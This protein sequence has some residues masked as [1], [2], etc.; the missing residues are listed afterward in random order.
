MKLNKEYLEKWLDG[1]KKAWETKDLNE[2]S[3]IFSKIENYWENEDTS[4]VKT[5]Q[6][7]LE[8]WK[9]VKN[10]KIKI[11]DFEII[12]INK[13]E[14]EIG[15]IFEDQS[16]KYNGIYKIKFDKNLNC[17]EFRQICF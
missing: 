6:E 8:L 17:V 12:S 3:K 11:L 5:I 7:V 10:Q 15:W 14:A 13:N 2:I 16:G 4:P 9:E 1:F